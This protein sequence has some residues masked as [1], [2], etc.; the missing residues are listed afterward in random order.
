M[1]GADPLLA[2]IEALLASGDAGDPA[3]IER[4]LTDGYARVLALEGE[5]RRI[6]RALDGLTAGAGGAAAASGA[7]LAALVRVLERRDDAIGALR[8]Q[9]RA[10]RRRHAAALRAGGA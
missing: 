5:Q 9:L 8:A 3:R 7:E 2:E 4:T 6:R 1:A 10:L